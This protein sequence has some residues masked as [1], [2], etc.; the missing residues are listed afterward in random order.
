MTEINTALNTAKSLSKPIKSESGDERDRVTI[1]DANRMSGLASGINP[2]NT[3]NTIMT[4]EKRRLEPVLKQKESTLM[5]IEAFR[6]VEEGLK[7]IKGS[8]ELLAGSGVWEGKTVESSNDE[9]VTATATSGA[10]PGKH[11]LVV[12]KLALN[13]QLVSQGY[14]NQDAQIGLG[15]F[16]ITVGEE[17]PISIVVDE[18]NNTLQGLKDAIN[19]ATDD[20]QATIIKTGNLERPYQLVIT[21]QTTGTAGRI[22]LE[23]DLRGGTPPNFGSSVESPSGWQGVGLE[24][25]SAT[26]TAKGTGASTSVVQVVGEYTGTED[27]TF[28]FTAVQTGVVGESP[29]LQVRWSDSEGNN[30]VLELDSFNYAPGETKEFVDG[31]AL[32]F[33]SGEIVVGDSFSFNASAEKPSTSWWLTEEERLASVSRPSA[34]SKQL[35]PTIG[36][37][38]IEGPYTGTDEQSFTLTVMGEGQIGESPGLSISWESDSGENG[39][40]RVG[41]GYEPGSKLA[42]IDGLTISLNPGVLASGQ[43]S[44]FDVIP[45]YTSDMWWKP[46]EERTVDPKIENITPWSVPDAEEGEG[47]LMPDL[48]QET[49]PRISNSQVTIGGQYTGDEAKTYTFTVLKDGGIGITQDLKIGWE[50]SLG[51]SGE[52]SVGDDYQM[53][54]ELPFDSGLSVSFGPGRVFKEDRFTLR[55]RTATIQPPQDAV[56][57][58]GATELGGGLEIVS[59]TNE[60]D[61]VIDGVRLNLQGMSDK[62]VTITIRGETEKALEL[63][64]TFVDEFN[65]LS[66][67]I[68]EVTKFD[69]ENNAAGPLL[70]S[71]DVTDIRQRLT[72]LVVDPVAGLPKDSNMLFTL[73]IRLNDQ[74]ALTLEESVLQKKIADNFGLVSDLFRNK[75]ESDN[76]QISFV[77]M[78]DKTKI[79]PDGYDVDITGVPTQGYYLSPMLMEPI[80]ITDQNNRFTIQVEGRESE[81]LELPIR[82]YTIGEFARVLQDAITNDK[83][84]GDTGVRVMIENNQIKVISGRFGERS[85]IA[86]TTAGYFEGGYSLLLDGQS[87]NGKNVEG[88]INGTPAQGDGILLKAG[89]ENGDA[90]GIRLLVRVSESKLRP[91]GPE[92]KIKITKGIAGRVGSYLDSLVNPLSGS[93]NNIGKGLRDQVK[94]LDQQLGQMNERISNK[95]ERLQ[96]KF[97][98]L[99]SQMSKLK[100]QQSYLSSQLK[101]GSGIPGLPGM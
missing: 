74:G 96:E 97:A 68:D 38:V 62:P 93:F 1:A 26:T 41:N 5:E 44:N 67:L 77:G 28:T 21:S 79:S 78:T 87:V 101:G 6:L 80:S 30:G 50:D 84:V 36:S 32:V 51:N 13:H 98:R 12:E 82:D 65:Q 60:L 37:P 95:R 22:S 23:I 63:V 64:R 57:R 46:E 71:R 3:I 70:G 33:S 10:K 83:M 91:D 11:T 48:P 66:A 18:T 15:K 85:S 73:G 86:F 55:T 54:V 27:K 2:Q 14:E 35:D 8:V 94:N 75:G 39:I 90:E 25:A 92:A 16:N 43:V 89:S 7:N 53:G 47:S 31:L 81:Q 9:A 56:I 40:L 69:E 58:F 99:E 52:L 42:L 34:W 45:G 4:V 19:F 59:S 72:E 88:T 24:E 100:S 29:Q 76:N 61:N 17:S 49:G 20:V